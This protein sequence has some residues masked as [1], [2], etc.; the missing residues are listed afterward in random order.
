MNMALLPNEEQRMLSVSAKAFLADAAPVA[1]LRA[2]RDSSDAIGYSV[3][4]WRDFANQGYSGILVPERFGGLGLSIV[5]AGLVAEELGRNLTPSPFLSTAVLAAVALERAGNEAQQKR[6]LPA[7]AESTTVLALA[8]DECAR[9]NPESVT[10]SAVRHG[11]GFALN[12]EKIFVVD[13]HVAQTLIV[14][15]R[16]SAHG[17]TLFLVD[18]DT[19]GVHIERTA[20]IDAHNAAR[21]RLQDVKV[22]AD[23]VLG[24]IDG[25]HGVLSQVLDHGRA[26]VAAQL[27]GAADA[28][29]ERTTTYLKERRQFG[30]LIGEFQALQHRAAQ[31]YVELELAR[32]MLTEALHALAGQS[33]DAGL[34]VARAKALACEA[35]SL[36]VREGVQMHGGMG[37]TDELDIGLFMKRVGVL[38]TLFGDTRFHLDRAATLSGY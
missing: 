28:V 25:G 16:T 19:A 36:A 9:H 3:S 5:E 18:R 37:M 21:V 11:D 31:W 12:G 34:M 20:M 22:G 29:F 33:A 15:A 30:R 13:G 7:I 26:I 17:I 4:L 35:A 10:L 38:Q 23:A 14:S 24:A 6:L 1:H 2:L 27:V 8:T 32:S